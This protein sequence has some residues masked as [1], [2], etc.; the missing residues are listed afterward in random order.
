MTALVPNVSRGSEKRF[1]GVAVTCFRFVISLHR[2][3]SNFHADY[4]IFISIWPCVALL[5]QWWVKSRLITAGPKAIMG[6]IQTPVHVPWKYSRLTQ[7]LT[8][9]IFTR[10]NFSAH[11]TTG[12][13]YASPV[14]PQSSAAIDRHWDVY[15]PTC[16]Y[17]HRH[18]EQPR[19][20]AV[21]GGLVGSVLDYGAASQFAFSV[22]ALF[23]GCMG[24]NPSEITF[25]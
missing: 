25:T 19:R 3:C 13:G 2:I 8:Y 11:C 16:T 20:N 4:R 21:L 23:P 5:T 14:V 9:C 18:A 17:T 1:F 6:L 7:F 12:L 22:K 24:S 10:S 15:N